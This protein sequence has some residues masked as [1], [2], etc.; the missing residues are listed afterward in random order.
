MELYLNTS[1]GEDEV[2]ARS[3]K[4]LARLGLR[5]AADKA[6]MC[7]LWVVFSALRRKAKRPGVLR[8]N[9]LFKT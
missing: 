6:G 5:L 8:Q 9:P 3:L 1:L 7:Q 4:E 2:T